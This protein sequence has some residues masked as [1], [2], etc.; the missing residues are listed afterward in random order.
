VTVEMLREYV[1]GHQQLC[2]PVQGQTGD[3]VYGY[4]FVLVA[5]L[6][7][8]LSVPLVVVLGWHPV[9]F[10]A[11]IFWLSTGVALLIYAESWFTTARSRNIQRD[12]RPWT[13]ILRPFYTD[14][15]VVAISAD[16]LPQVSGRF[17]SRVVELLSLIGPPVA[18]ASPKDAFD[19][20]GALRL[21]PKTGGWQDLVTDLASGAALVALRLDETEGIQWELVH[22]FNT[23][24]L[25]RMVIFLSRPDGSA[26]DAAS[27]G[28]YYNT[29]DA[30]VRALLPLPDR[31]TRGRFILYERPEGCSEY[32]PILIED[33]GRYPRRGWFGFVYA[34]AR[35][36]KKLLSMDRYKAAFRKPPR[37]APLM[38]HLAR[39]AGSWTAAT[40]AIGI[41]TLIILNILMGPVRSGWE[42][43]IPKPPS[44]FK[45]T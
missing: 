9:G 36:E 10:G 5:F 26:M 35:L 43:F 2:K 3:A 11:A 41:V 39:K 21:K 13:L 25:D 14:E 1:Q 12:D 23:I 44:W 8:F 18:L 30:S 28:K 31:V 32:R 15:E 38:L 24:P 16:N 33:D 34:L 37:Y 20:V 17:E 27:Y 29:A 19:G 22:L 6:L 7:I 45:S 4:A 42:H 40:I